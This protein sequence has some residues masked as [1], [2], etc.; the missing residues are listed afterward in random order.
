MVRH[1]TAARRAKRSGQVMT[2]YIIVLS[3][4]VF[5]A[6]ALLSLVYFTTRFGDRMIESVSM[7]Y[8]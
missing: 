5:V 6:I 7:E 8:P 4:M 2:E 3:T 1:R